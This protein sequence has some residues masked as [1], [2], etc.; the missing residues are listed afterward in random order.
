M[1]LALTF[2]SVMTISFALGAMGKGCQMENE[3]I[4]HGAAHYDA[5]T[6]EFTWNN[7][8]EEKKPK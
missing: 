4:K 2:I 3:V 7:P 5:K 8:I 6:G 1:N